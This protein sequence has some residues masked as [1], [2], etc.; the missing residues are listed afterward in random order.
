M[1]V[2]VAIVSGGDY[3]CVVCHE[4]LKE[5]DVAVAAQSQ[6]YINKPLHLNAGKTEKRVLR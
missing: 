6:F 2:D 5:T 1:N 4:P 3:N